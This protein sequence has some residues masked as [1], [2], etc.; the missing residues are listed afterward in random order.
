MLSQLLRSVE[1][2]GACCALM[3]SIWRMRAI[4]KGWYTY[5]ILRWR[6]SWSPRFPLVA[7]DFGQ[8]LQWKGRSPVWV[9]MWFLRVALWSKD[10][11]QKLHWKIFFATLRIALTESTVSSWRYNNSQN[12]YFS[13]L[14]ESESRYCAL[15]ICFHW[16]LGSLSEACTHNI[17]HSVLLHSHSSHW[18]SSLFE[19]L[20]PD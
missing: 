19:C 14:I 6:R 9:R 17:S 5:F 7:K 2:L 20:K 18:I 15:I 13:F 3:A 12:L 1:T 11:S 8:Y 10:W 4:L 16:F